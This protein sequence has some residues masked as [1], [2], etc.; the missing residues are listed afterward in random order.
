MMIR[1]AHRC[2]LLAVAVAV[3]FNCAAAYPD[4][5]IKVVMPFPPG[6]T[7]DVVM[8]LVSAE[9][10][11]ALGKPLVLEYKPGA[12][13]GIATEAVARAQP[14]GYTVLVVTPNH[15]INPALNAH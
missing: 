9:A 8:R 11:E 4:K 3:A 1:A 14:D 13:G 2:C 10:G 6:G 12:A 7:V 15:T 5:P